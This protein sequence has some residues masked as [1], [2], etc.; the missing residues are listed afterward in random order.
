MIMAL[1]FSDNQDV[2]QATLVDELLVPLQL[3]VD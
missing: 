2:N 1:E 3:T